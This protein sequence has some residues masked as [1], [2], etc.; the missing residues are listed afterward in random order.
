MKKH[1]KAHNF[2]PDFS[3]VMVIKRNLVKELDAISS[4]KYI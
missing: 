2:Q 1:M 3:R 4:G